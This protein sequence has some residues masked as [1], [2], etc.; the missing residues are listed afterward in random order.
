MR[1]TPDIVRIICSGCRCGYTVPVEW[2]GAAIEF[3]CSC[4]TRLKPDTES[5]LQVRFGMAVSPEI[6]L[7]S[8][9]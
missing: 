2:L 6:V 3:D 8:F 5:L 9:E 4:G 7:S 1:A